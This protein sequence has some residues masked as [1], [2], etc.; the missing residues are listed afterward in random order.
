MTKL[1]VNQPTLG[2]QYKDTTAR[3]RVSINFEHVDS[4]TEQNHLERVK[5]QN[6]IKQYTAQG[7]LD[8]VNFYEGQYGDFV[9]SLDFNQAMNIAAET[10][11]MFESLPAEL[12]RRFNDDPADY[13]DF[14]QNPENRVEMEELGIP[15]SHLP[16]QASSEAPQASSEAPQGT[17]DPVQSPE[18]S[19]EGKPSQN[20]SDDV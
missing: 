17:I 9:N 19:G 6:I 10:T 14:V 1:T 2:I 5:I 7:M 8:H 4:M 12:R 11:Q 16:P 18:P 15:T 3:R 20:P 13:L